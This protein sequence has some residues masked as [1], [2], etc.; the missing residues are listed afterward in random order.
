MAATIRQRSSFAVALTALA[1][2][3]LAYAIGSAQAESGSEAELRPWRRCP[4]GWEVRPDVNGKRQ[5]QRIL[6]ISN[7]GH[8]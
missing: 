7:F 6:M 1:I 8:L 3:G 4:P 5:A 2:L